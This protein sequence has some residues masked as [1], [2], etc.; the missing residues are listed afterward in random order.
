MEPLDR[1]VHFGQVPYIILGSHGG[2][3]PSDLRILRMLVTEGI[4]EADDTPG[5]NPSP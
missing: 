5:R 1:V 4:D 3:R 2:C